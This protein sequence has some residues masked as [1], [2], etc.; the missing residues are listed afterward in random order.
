MDGF[1]TV[2]QSR[3]ICAGNPN[4]PNCVL[5]VK[6]TD[7][8]GYHDA[9]EIPHYWTYAK[10][11]VLQDHLFEP[12]YGWSLP[13][14]LFMVSGWAASCPRPTDPMSCR[15]DLGVGALNEARYGPRPQFGWTDLTYL[16]HA[17]GVTWGDF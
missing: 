4:A 1:I 13:A 12:N 3:T 11:F 16:L 7:V 6:H 15:S 9:R 17:H 5:R 14:H 2:A 10:D 8:M